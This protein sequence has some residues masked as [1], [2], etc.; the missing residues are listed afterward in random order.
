MIRQLLSR[1]AEIRS[2][3]LIVYHGLIIGLYTLFTAI[4]TYPVITNMTGAIMGTGDAWQVLYILWYTKQALLGG[5]PGMTM[6]YTNYIFYPNG[7]PMIFSSFSLFDQLIG[8]PLQMLFGLAATYNIVWLLSFI[9]AGYG[10]FLLVRYLTGNDTAAFV[11]GIIYAFSPYHFEQAQMHIGATTI[12]WIPFCALFLM[13]MFREKDLKS[14]FLAGVFFILV[15]LSD[16]QYMM[17]MVM[18][19]GLLFL[20]EIYCIAREQWDKTDDKANVAQALR[21]AIKAYKNMFIRYA[22]FGITS[23]AGA[24]PAN[25]DL[26][27]IAFSN[28][29]FLVE[30]ASDATTYSGDLMGFLI[31]S[32]LHPLF[33]SWVAS[34]YTDFTGNN[35][36]YIT[37]IGMTVLALSIFAIV[38][39]RK[40]KEVQFWA[41]SAVLF[42]LM[43]L[44]PVLHVMG[45]IQTSWNIFNIPMPYMLAFN[46]IPFIGD[47]R[48]P[49]RFDVL[50]MLSFAVLAGYGLARLMALA[51]T[52]RKGTI[53]ALIAATL[54]IFEFVSV[55]A[56]STVDVPAFY[57]Q[58]GQDTGNYAVIEIPASV[59]YEAGLK[60]E[61]YETIS[62]KPMVGGQIPRT[63]AD[64]SNFEINTPLIDDI[65]DPDLGQGLS[66]K[67]IFIQNDTEIGN[68]V[69][70]YY[71]IS[72]VILHTDYMDNMSPTWVENDMMILNATLNE[73]PTYAGD[74]LV[75]YKVPQA[76][77]AAYIYPG[78][79][80]SLPVIDGNDTW[81]PAEN[82]SSIHI[83]NPYDGNYTLSFDVA[84]LLPDSLDIYVNGENLASQQTAYEYTHVDIPVKLQ[85]GDNTVSFN[86]TTVNDQT[87]AIPP[88]MQYTRFMFE[89]VSVERVDGE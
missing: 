56:I 42:M 3:I 55:P 87:L 32:P 41:L 12:E 26:L 73:S 25:Y 10:T 66:G 69:L 47:S 49:D 82:V 7:V 71:N 72:Y 31:P 1:F 88:W 11:S 38:L 22:V 89:N 5:N 2:R 30:K 80:F 64:A 13:K 40:E 14:A 86:S 68:T 83:I 48:T 17:F 85:A 60:C 46:Y 9:L 65:S 79:G 21:A 33:G 63:P 20:F 39:R 81:R 18:L 35:T 78:D 6:T 44:G 37:Y 34:V 53:I 54:I 29:N 24:I 67:D 15:A 16:S 52:P 28:S 51:K 61:Y 4:L 8:V 75:V 27:K 50:V 36:E 45:S 23:L 77:T 62:D 59:N 58:L 43:V 74:N 57:Q 76:P 84:S 70:K 19:V